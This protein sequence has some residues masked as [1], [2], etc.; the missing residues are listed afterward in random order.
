MGWREREEGSD[1][2]GSDVDG[3]DIN[4]QTCV[5]MQDGM[6]DCVVDGIETLNGYYQTALLDGKIK[7]LI[8]INHCT[9]SF[10]RA[11]VSSRAEVSACNERL[12]PDCFAGWED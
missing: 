3:N 12:L 4:T 7:P 1:D 5:F 6:A 9:S 11:W 8:L 10:H 2:A